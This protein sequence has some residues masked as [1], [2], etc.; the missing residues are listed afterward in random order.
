MKILKYIILSFSGLFF[1]AGCS[2]WLEVKP[3]DT[4]AEGDLLSTEEGFKKLLNGV[5]IDLNK[6]ELYGQTL[7]VEMV[8]IMTWGDYIDLNNRNFTTSI[9]VRDST[10]RGTRRMH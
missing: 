9:G 5:Y 4:M 1:T 10:I 6:D 2:D 8:E 7:T 3:Y